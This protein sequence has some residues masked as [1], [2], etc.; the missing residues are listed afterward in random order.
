MDAGGCQ[1]RPSTAVIRTGPSPSEICLKLRLCYNNTCALP[2]LAQAAPPKQKHAHNQR[3]LCPSPHRLEHVDEAGLLCRHAGVEV[4][5]DGA[6]Q[7]LLQLGASSQQLGSGHQAA[8]SILQTQEIQNNIISE[9]D[10]KRR[11]K[12]GVHVKMLCVT[13]HK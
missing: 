9:A 5:L 2:A 10:M 1:S 7:P 12:R 11:L 6:V 4:V 13:C 3:R 8:T